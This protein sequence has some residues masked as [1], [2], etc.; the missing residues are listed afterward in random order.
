[1]KGDR[2]KSK[3][4][5][6]RQAMVYDVLGIE[7]IVHVGGS[8]SDGT[9][10][11]AELRVPAGA[12]IPRHYHA[13]EDEIFHVVEGR[14]DFTVGNEALTADIGTTLFAPRMTPHSLTAADGRPAR[15]LITLTPSGLEAMFA[16]IDKLPKGPPDMAVISEIVGRYGI[17]F[18]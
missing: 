12:G 8:E 5:S 7:H 6:S 10:S 18:V 14:V 2:M 15:L 9:I 17:S 4:T 16:E 11:F 3:I 1:M 13:R